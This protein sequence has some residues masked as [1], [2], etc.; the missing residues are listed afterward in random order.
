M[1]DRRPPSAPP[2]VASPPQPVGPL[3]RPS[4]RSHHSSLI[5]LCACLLAAAIP[6]VAQQY[7]S[8]PV[9]M[10]LPQAPGS[11]TDTVGRIVFAATAER[12]NQQ[13]VVDNRPGAGG[14]MGMEIASR[15][16]PDGYTLVG[17]AA[18]M[19]AIAPHVYRKLAYDPLGDFVPVGLFI[20]S[21]T[22]LC[23]HT[24]LPA[25]SVQDVVRLAREHPGQLNMASA[26][27]GSTSHLAGVLFSTL[28]G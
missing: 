3:L 8:R 28:A 19:L 6:G 17:V 15:A 27:I 10:L 9:R 5:L 16:A 21:N 18:S 12:L 22:A 11:T 7:P 20:L 13:L 14:T 2:G 4:T 24:K 26:G 25:K 23:V 1:R